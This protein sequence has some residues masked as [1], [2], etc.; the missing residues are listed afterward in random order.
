MRGNGEKSQG[1][2]NLQRERMRV[3]R[4]RMRAATAE[5]GDNPRAH[6]TT[7][8]RMRAGSARKENAR[9]QR[10]KAVRW[11]KTASHAVAAPERRRGHVSKLVAYGKG[12]KMA[13][14]KG[15]AQAPTSPR[16]AAAF[17]KATHGNARYAI[18]NA[19]VYY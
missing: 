18:A 11:Q 17:R 15:C 8:E 19:R 6:A 14:Q 7:R 10:K 4:E 2:D 13:R 9:R 1:A 16:R 3:Q 12:A 5:A